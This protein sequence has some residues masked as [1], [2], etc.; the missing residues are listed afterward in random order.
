[1]AILEVKNIVKKLGKKEVL[2][3]VNFSVDRGEIY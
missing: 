2:H 1:M 3:S